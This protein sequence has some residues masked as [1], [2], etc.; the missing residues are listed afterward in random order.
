MKLPGDLRADVDQAL[1]ERGA[2]RIRSAAP[3][4]GGC[5]AETA[6]IITGDQAHFFLKWARADGTPAGLFAQEARSLEALGATGALRVPEV[7]DVR[8]PAE[9]T[10]R[11]R[12][13][14]LEWLEPGRTAAHTWPTLAHGLVAL[15][16]RR[17]S[18][19]GWPTDNF[20]GRLPQ[21]NAELADW[22]RFWRERRLEPQLRRARDDGRL[23]Q[24]VAERFDAL[25]SE[26]DDI[27]APAADEGPSLLHGDL[28]SGNLHV[29]RGGDPALIDP[30]TYHGHREVD[31]AMTELFGGFDPFFRAAY[32]ERWPLA[33]DHERRQHVYQL[34]YLLVHVNLFGAGYRARTLAALDA[35]GF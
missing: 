20:I 6:R 4:G 30:S 16:E 33:P 9:A 21:A 5:I 3:V 25:H 23:E 17:G 22:P 34:Y 27:L 12:W 15:H 28:W 18:T 35:A 26:L 11:P 8:D 32:E 1:G 13:L 7:V 19:W 10:A 24:D 29:M 14:L 31:L 2:G